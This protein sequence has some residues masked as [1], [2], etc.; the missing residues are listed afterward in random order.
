MPLLLKR[1]EAYLI[2]TWPMQELR[3]AQVKVNHLINVTNEQHTCTCGK[4]SLSLL[5]LLQLVI[6]L[7]ALQ[8]PYPHRLAAVPVLA[9]PCQQL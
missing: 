1:G 4:A 6:S 9:V 7:Q 3:L 2:P 5:L 8:I